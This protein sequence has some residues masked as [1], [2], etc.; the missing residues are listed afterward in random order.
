MNIKKISFK[1]GLISTLLLPFACN[2][3]KDNNSTNSPTP[4]VTPT[5][6]Q[7]ILSTSIPSYSVTP[8]PNTSSTPVPS[9]S[10]ST[11][12]I[13]KYIKTGTS[14]G[15]CAGYCNQEISIDADKIVYTAIPSGRGDNNYP[16]INTTIKFSSAEFQKLQNLVELKTFT[17][18]PDR[19]GCPDCADGGAEWVEIKANDTVK[20]VTFE[21]SKEVP[22][23]KALVEKLRVIRKENSNPYSINQIIADFSKQPKKNPPIIINSYAYKGQKV[24]YVP[25]Y[26]CDV[27]STLYDQ[28]GKK[29]CSPDG[30]ITGKGDGT[31]SDFFTERKNEL[32]I[33]KDTR[34]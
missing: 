1:I 17:S 33:W 8:I 26:C 9:S 10:A 11:T 6:T 4:T 13:I 15:M 23:I 27:P 32:L 18:L 20:R 24:Y 12:S 34:N 28:E 21:Y 5:T 29:L 22:E 25:S 3:S 30:G 14:F 7:S 19:I 31:C 16:E 2:S